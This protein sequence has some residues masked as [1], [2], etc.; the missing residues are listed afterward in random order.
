MFQLYHTPPAIVRKLQMSE[1]RAMKGSKAWLSRMSK[2]NQSDGSG[3]QGK[4]VVRWGKEQECQ[5]LHLTQE[6]KV[7]VD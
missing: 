1:I 3:I 5:P 2:F 4:Y 6:L 7:V